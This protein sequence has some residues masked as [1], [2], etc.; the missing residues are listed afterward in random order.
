M[1]C[2]CPH[3]EFIARD[4]DDDKISSIKHEGRR[5]VDHIWWRSINKH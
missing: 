4:D 2:R 5:D 1:W 3:F